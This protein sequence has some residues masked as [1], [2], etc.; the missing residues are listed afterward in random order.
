MA[1]AATQSVVEMVQLP[2]LLV[3]LPQ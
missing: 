2:W 1:E 3:E